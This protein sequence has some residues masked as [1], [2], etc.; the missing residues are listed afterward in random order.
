MKKRM[1]IKW[2]S[3]NP[4]EVLVAAGVVVDSLHLN[5]IVIPP[6][7]RLLVEELGEGVVA[8]RTDAQR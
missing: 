3:T 4:Q 2:Q 6:L 5:S 8:G 1:F 7:L